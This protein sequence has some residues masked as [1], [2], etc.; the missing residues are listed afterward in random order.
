MSSGIARR[1]VETFHR[2][3]LV[4]D[5]ETPLT[6]REEEILALLAQG[7]RYREIGEELFISIDT[8]RTHIRHIYEKMHVRSRAEATLKYLGRG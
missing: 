8:V 6:A 4:P 3:P 2:A 5:H 7:Y 1:I